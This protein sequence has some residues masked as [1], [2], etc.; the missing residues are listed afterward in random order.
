MPALS[1]LTMRVRQA[2]PE[3]ARQRAELGAAVSAFNTMATQFNTDCGSIGADETAKIQNCKSRLA[4]LQAERDVLIARSTSFNND[5]AET[6][7]Y[8]PYRPSGNGLVGGTGWLVGYN[9]PKPTP[10]LIAKARAM[11]AEQERLAGHAYV[12]AIDFDRYNFV[13]GIAAETNF[14][15]DLL[16]RVGLKDEMTEGK[17]SIEHQPGYA[18][19]AGRSFRELG[20]H[21]NGAMICL[22]ALENRDV[23]ADNIVLYG[24][25]VTRESLAMWNRLVQDGRV[26][27]VK[28]YVNENDI[29]PGV[30]IAFADL[31]RKR[32]AD[33]PALFQID[34]LKRT[35]NELSPR[36]LVQ[37]FPCSRDKTSLECHAMS[38]Y[39]SKV[40]CTGRRSGKAVPGTALHGKDELP[41]PPL[42]C[43]SIGGKP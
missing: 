35:I 6:L 10:E 21:S 11:L 14:F 1:G 30:S 34:T 4:Q 31:K 32:A 19:L 33:E 15:D 39:E 5:V 12:D 22:A 23:K 24:P 41:E 13:I 3:Y 18:A 17:Y 20:C 36:L 2:H 26:K 27:S 40:N 29:V 42:P 25:Q 7:E 16:D 8:A 37:T 38:M 28:I 43:E 9:V